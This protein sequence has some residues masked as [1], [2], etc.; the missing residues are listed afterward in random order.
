MSLA[1]G[2]H[3]RLDHA[4]VTDIG[5]RRGIF[6]ITVGKTIGRGGQPQ[7]LSR[8]AANPLTIHGQVCS[9]SC[10]YHAK[11]FC[12]QLQQGGRGDGL[13]LRDDIVRLFVLDHRTQRL[14]IKHVDHMTTMRHLHR[15]G[16]R[17]TIDRDHLATQALQFDDQLLAQLTGA[18][19]QYA[20]R[21][22]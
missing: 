20:G 16:V 14:G 19:Q 3:H 15:R 22:R 4:G 8:Q 10:R 2:A 1:G 6:G 9:A 11:A 13:D 5:N 12:F 17:I 21:C 7:L 18:T